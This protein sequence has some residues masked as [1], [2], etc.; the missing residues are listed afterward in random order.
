MKGQPCHVVKARIGRFSIYHGSFHTLKEKRYVNDDVKN[1]SQ[2][3]N[4]L[5]LYSV[6][7]VDC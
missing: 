7:C 1:K 4:Y 5:L 6:L 3:T 2:Y